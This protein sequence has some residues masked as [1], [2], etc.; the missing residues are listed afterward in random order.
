MHNPHWLDLQHWYGEPL[1]NQFGEAEAAALNA[2]LTT[3][4]GQ[5]LLILGAPDGVAI[6]TGSAFLSPWR[7]DWIPPSPARVPDLVAEPDALPIASDCIDVAVLYHVLEYVAEPYAV[8]REIERV[9]V[10]EGYVVTLGFNPYSPVGLWRGLRLRAAP[11]GGRLVSVPRLGDWLRRLG[12]EHRGARYCFYW[13]WASPPPGR[14]RPTL[15]QRLGPRWWPVLGGSYVVLAKK[16]VIPLTLI[17]QRWRA[18]H[19]PVPS[20]LVRPVAKTERD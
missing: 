20:G 18:R 10:P 19:Y 16:R 13:P 5:R 12:L 8:L 7:M 14:A 2:L 15:T 17:K 6:G 11:R 1:G 9:L 3:V 4:P